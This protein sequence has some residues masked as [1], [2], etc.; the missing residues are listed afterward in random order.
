[1]PL[2]LTVSSTVSLGPVVDLRGVVDTNWD[3]DGRIF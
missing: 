2:G 1:M 3:R